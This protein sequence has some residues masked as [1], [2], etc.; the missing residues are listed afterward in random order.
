MVRSQV[1]PLVSL[2]LWRNISAGRLQLELKHNPSLEKHW[3]YLLKKEAKAKKSAGDAFVPQ[4]SKPEVWFLPL[5]C[6]EFVD[7]LEKAV[8]VDEV[9]GVE[10]VEPKASLYCERFLEFVSD[11]LSQ[12]PTR[13]FVRTLLEDR[14]LAVKCNLSPLFQNPKEGR[15]FAQLTDLFRFYQVINHTSIR[16]RSV[17]FM[18]HPSTFREHSVTFRKDSVNFGEHSVN[19]Q[20]IYQTNLPG[21]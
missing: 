19:Y 9:T 1:L 21:N 15:L 2:P 7:T 17:N 20:V 6:D 12:L 8:V 16:E 10:T 18:E 11:L 4:E 3:R 13:R 5:L 14:A